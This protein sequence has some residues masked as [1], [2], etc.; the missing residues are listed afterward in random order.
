MP[1]RHPTT[2]PAPTRAHRPP[3]ALDRVRERTLRAARLLAE[4]RADV[5]PL[6]SGRGVR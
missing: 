2:I 3:T 5:A 1:D 4:A 6:L